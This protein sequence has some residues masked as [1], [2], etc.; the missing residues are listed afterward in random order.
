MNK[1]RFLHEEKLKDHSN[2]GV[3]GIFSTTKVEWK[4][5]VISYNVNGNKITLTSELCSYSQEATYETILRH[6]KE[7]KTLEEGKQFIQNYKVKWESG[8]NNTTQEVRDKKLDDILD[9]DE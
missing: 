3:Y 4:Y 9:T 7:F 8:S 6:G 1:G 2:L 5:Y